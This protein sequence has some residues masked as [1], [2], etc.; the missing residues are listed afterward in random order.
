MG[1]SSG[2]AEAFCVSCGQKG[3]RAA[4]GEAGSQAD[5]C[6]PRGSGCPQGAVNQKEAGRVLWV[7]WPRCWAV[8]VLQQ[9]RAFTAETLNRRDE[10]VSIQQAFLEHLGCT[11]TLPDFGALVLGQEEL[12]LG[13]GDDGNKPFYKIEMSGG[14]SSAYASQGRWHELRPQA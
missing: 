6:I 2:E 14:M 9:Q 11:S 10:H 5:R 12:V 3:G 8:I 4:R 1:R 7:L 13:E